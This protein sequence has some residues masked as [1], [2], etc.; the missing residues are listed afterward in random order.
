MGYRKGVGHTPWVL[1]CFLP[2][3]GSF[4]AELKHLNHKKEAM[5]SET[6]RCVAPAL[7]Y[8]SQCPYCSVSALALSVL[9]SDVGIP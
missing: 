7:V 5:V 1:L 3:T 8:E 9:Q 6:D 4:R 2:L